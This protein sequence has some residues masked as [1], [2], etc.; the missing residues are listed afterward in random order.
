[1]FE[2]LL[3]LGWLGP[4]LIAIA[5]YGIF[6]ASM[7]PFKNRKR[8]KRA[9]A[10][11]E[12]R[13]AKACGTH[14]LARLWHRTTWSADASMWRCA[15]AVC[16]FTGTLMIAV[17]LI[18]SVLSVSLGTRLLTRMTA[19]SGF[20]WSTASTA[21]VSVQ[22][23]ARALARQVPIGAKSSAPALVSAA[24]RPSVVTVPDRVRAV[25]PAGTVNP[26]PRLAATPQLRTTPSIKPLATNTLQASEDSLRSLT[27]S[28][29]RFIAQ[30]N[31][32]DRYVAPYVRADGTTVRGHYRTNPDGIEF[33]NYSA[34]LGNLYR[35]Q[36]GRTV[37]KRP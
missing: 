6:V 17:A 20:Q 8:A 7:R 14:A 22:D 12:R 4:P 31:A 18:A 26:A 11:C 16:A 5:A 25:S 23:P 34:P 21:H 29:R 19:E 37:S 15:S 9:A 3:K 13:A 32:G 28:E 2:L 10:L 36:N 24:S 35:A 27:P 30:T 33:N 1:M